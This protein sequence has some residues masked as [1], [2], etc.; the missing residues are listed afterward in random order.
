L[1]ELVR[2]GA[3]FSAAANVTICFQPDLKVWEVKAE[4]SSCILVNSEPKVSV[5]ERQCIT[6]PIAGGAFAISLGRNSVVI[7]E[8]F[9]EI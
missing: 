9:G 3:D 6:L 5:V 7:D 8:P 1:D 4:K 2:S